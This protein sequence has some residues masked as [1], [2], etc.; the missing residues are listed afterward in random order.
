MS[1]GRG[2]YSPQARQ[3][4][5]QALS[6]AA[7]QVRPVLQLVHALLQRIDQRLSLLH[8]VPHLFWCLAGRLQGQSIQQQ[9]H[10]GEPAGQRSADQ[11]A[12]ARGNACKVF[13]IELSLTCDHQSELTVAGYRPKRYC[14]HSATRWEIEMSGQRAE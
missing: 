13:C 2:I 10:D 14:L 11:P 4:Q 7:R 1:R 6:E 3:Q 8:M 5:Q 12:D 9:K